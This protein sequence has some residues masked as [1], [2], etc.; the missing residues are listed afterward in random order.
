MEHRDRLAFELHG[1]FI[2]KRG[3]SVKKCAPEGIPFG[4]D[5]KVQL[6]KART[7]HMKNNTSQ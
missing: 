2:H 3:E 1:V 4:T 5:G 6:S 7:T